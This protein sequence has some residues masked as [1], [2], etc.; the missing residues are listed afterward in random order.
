MGPRRF[1]LF[2][3]GMLLAGILGLA[4]SGALA[5]AGSETGPAYPVVV[6]FKGVDMSAARSLYVP[7]DRA[8][9]QA[10]A[11]S[12][13]DRGVAGSV[14]MM[15]IAHG[16]VTDHVYSHA[17]RGF[18]A[19]VTARQLA[20]LRHDP[21]VAFV[22]AD[23]VWTRLVQTLPWGID[24]VDADQSSQR[25]GNRSG[26]VT[27]VTVYV[28]DTGV[29]TSS[30]LNRVGHVTMIG[31]TN[32]DCSGHGTH[33]AGTAAA[34]DN[35][36]LVVGVAPG[37][38]L[39]GVKVLDCRGQGTLLGVIKGIDWVTANARRP[40][41]VNMS[42][43]GTPSD[44]GDQAVLTSVASGIFYAVAAG[45]DGGNACDLSPARLGRVPGVMTVAATDRT[46]RER[47]WSNY[48]PCVDIWAPGVSIVS[49]W[50]NNVTNTLSG[51]SMATP[52][53]TGTAALYLSTFPAAT[54]ADVESALKIFAR[55]TGT[56]SKDGRP[57]LLAYA[58]SF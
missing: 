32:A 50:L 9:A 43:G 57:I 28:I 40:A 17:M 24:R 22:E 13:L 19:R 52:H 35:T 47:A 7:D 26:A 16:F 27:N 3:T 42:L 18:A 4:L 8:R 23:A 36:L 31:G 53:V 55:I 37:A 41:V 39:T 21:R 1:V 25:A 38:P 46:N 29:G 5:P 48:G 58:G 10:E 12:Y 14:Q 30:D 20:A 45:N 11:W 2:S 49:T 33:V 15:E 34:R 6:V 44:A 51:T 54:P 56:L